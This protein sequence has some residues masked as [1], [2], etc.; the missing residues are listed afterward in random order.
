MKQ[1][2]IVHHLSLLNDD[3]SDE[4]WLFSASGRLCLMR[5]KDGKR[6][7]RKNGGFDPDYVVCTFPLI[8]ND[9]GDW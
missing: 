7:M 1:E 4:Y 3:W 5:K 8:E 9:G 2:D 6:V